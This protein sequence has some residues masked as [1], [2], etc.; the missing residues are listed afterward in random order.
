MAMKAEKGR[1]SIMT[2]QQ[3][4]TLNLV[5]TYLVIIL[6][7]CVLLFPIA[8]MISAAFKT[9]DEIFGSIALLPKSFRFQNFIDGWKSAGIYTY[10][11]YFINSFIM[12][13]PTTL[14]TIASSALVAYGFARFNF[15]FK[16]SCLPSCSPP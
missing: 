2:K 9:N 11:T 6:I 16:S 14:L 13:I 10:A 1:V 15:P 7:G 5:L 8:W 3:K 4:K 12:V